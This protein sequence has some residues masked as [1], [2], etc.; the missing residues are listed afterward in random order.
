MKKI[1]VST[2]LLLAMNSFAAAPD[3]FEC[4]GEG[5]KIG[6]WEDADGQVGLRLAAGK[7]RIKIDTTIAASDKI[8]RSPSP[9]GTLITAVDQAFS[10]GET[11]YVSF[12]LPHFKFTSSRTSLAFVTSLIEHV[13]KAPSQVD[14]LVDQVTRVEMIKCQALVS[15]EPEEMAPSAI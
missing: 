11:S 6:Y 15:G 14:G 12:V 10:N 2:M 13:T 8:M 5:I 3:L 9:I 7:K 4:E 1:F